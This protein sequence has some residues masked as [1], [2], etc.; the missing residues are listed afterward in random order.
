MRRAMW[1]DLNAL[2]EGDPRRRVSPSLGVFAF[3]GSGGRSY[4]WGLD[5]LLQVR[6]SGSFTASIGPHFDRNDDD[7]QWIGNFDHRTDPAST[8]LDTSYTFAHLHQSTIAMTTR[9]DL[10]LTPTLSLQVYAQP[11]VSTGKYRNWRELNDVRNAD[12]DSGTRRTHLPTPPSTRTTSTILSSGRTPCCGGSIVPAHPFSSCGPRDV[13]CWTRAW[14]RHVRFSRQCARPVR[15]ASGE[16]ISGE[17][18]VLVLALAERA[19]AGHHLPAAEQR[20]GRQD[21]WARLVEE[22]HAGSAARRCQ[23]G[24]QSRPPPAGVGCLRPPER[25][26]TQR[27]DGIAESRRH[28]SD[29]MRDIVERH[30]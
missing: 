17:D 23:P 7:H 20:D 30:H 10:T 28:P 9:V 3:R 25:Q 8:R 24:Q 4:G 5:P 29:R 1:G 12:Y 21:E 13:R 2:I 19:N 15:A 22:E 11:F 14:Q 18:V 6:L 16:H 26:R 27:D